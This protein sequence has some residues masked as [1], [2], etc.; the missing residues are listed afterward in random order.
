MFCFVVINYYFQNS[1]EIPTNNYNTEI[2]NFTTIKN[3]FTT[4]NKQ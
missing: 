1:N 4:I 2:R 3:T